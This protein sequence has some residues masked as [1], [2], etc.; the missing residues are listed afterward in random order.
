MNGA[1]RKAL[2]RFARRIGRWIIEHLARRGA[3]MLRG[4]MGGKIDDFRRR[5]KSAQ[6]ERRRIWLRGR[7]RRWSAVLRW[8]EA[9][10]AELV[11][12][13]GEAFDALARGE[14]KAI[15]MVC[16]DAMPG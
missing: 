3:V 4:Y 14:A 8:L 12:C 5:L 1:I 16:E 6:T 13:A 10:T 7:I 9:N 11:G 15:P 2:L